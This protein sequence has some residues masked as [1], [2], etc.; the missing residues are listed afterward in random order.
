MKSFY[1]CVIVIVLNF[2]V[3]SIESQND[4]D[5]VDI[6]LSKQKKKQTQLENNT[7]SKMVHH[8]DDWDC[9]DSENKP[10][11]SLPYPCI[12]CYMNESCVYGNQTI[13]TCKANVKCVGETTFA[14]NLTCRFCYQ[15][16][17]WEHKCIKKTMCNS[18]SSP[19]SYYRTNCTVNRD[20]L[21]L[22]NRTFYKRLR[23]NWTGGHRWST[24]LILS[25]TLGGFGVDRFYLGHWQE[26]IG[27]LFSFGGLGVWTLIDVL[28][29][30]IRYL[31]PADGSLYL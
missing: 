9:S 31:G 21:C 23:C 18:A 3:I 25:I 26:G 17:L 1:H 19:P 5:H 27:K 7:H 6:S 12:H 11:S 15:T 2:I 10:C 4:D 20:V 29:I 8:E 14:K 16:E 13:A 28:L 22:G 24:A 30:S